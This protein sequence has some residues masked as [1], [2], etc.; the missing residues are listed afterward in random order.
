MNN[1]IQIVEKRN[2]IE[3]HLDDGR[4]LSGPRGKTIEEFLMILP[5]WAESQ[6]MGAVVNNELRELTYSLEMDARLKPL[7]MVNPDGARIYR[8][9]LTFLLQAT[10]E[11]LFP[12]SSLYIDH[13]ITHGGYYCNVIDRDP[14]NEEEI[15]S[16]YNKMKELVSQDIKF[17]KKQVP[18]AEAIAYF[19]EH[20]QLDKVRLLKFRNKSH[21]VLYDL[22]GHLDYH[23]GYMVPSTGYLKWFNLGRMGEGFVINFPRRGAPTKIA[24]VPKSSGLIDTFYQY[25]KW[26]SNLGIND[27]GTLNEAIEKNRMQEIILVTEALHEQII[28]KI[29]NKIVKDLKESRVVLISGPSSS[30]KT[31]FSKRLAVQL[32]THGVSPFPLEMDNYFVNRE[33]TPLDEKGQYDFESIK[34]MNIKLLV[35]QLDQLLSGDEI[36]L[37][38]YDFKSGK[39]A[40][41]EVV[42][43]HADQIII[44]EGIHGLNPALTGEENRFKTMKIYAS[45]LTQLNLDRYNR[46]S[47]TDSRL[48]RRIVRDARERGYSASETIRRWESVRRGERKYIFQ[49]QD[50]AS[51]MFNSAL[52]YELSALKPLAEPLLRQVPFGTYEYIEAKRL[53]AFLDWFIPIQ[54]EKIPNNSIIREFIG[55][56]ILKDFNLWKTTDLM[57]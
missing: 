40:P 37:P 44:M 14:L 1:Q 22:E 51:E 15:K 39:S 10:F 53:L 2:T 26:L 41:G 29:A 21:L 9:S 34:A 28:A 46:I 31:T 18:L 20:Q 27:V 36:Q 30:G 13:S 48:L 3:V 7:R 54:K 43:L 32:L 57:D 4:V 45:C 17:N 8:R 5:G 25:S 47:T 33:D 56:T 42:Q 49:Y 12:N 24:K 35:Q 6:T 38:H 52:V 16:L 19:E 50:N 23:H 55:G 11:S